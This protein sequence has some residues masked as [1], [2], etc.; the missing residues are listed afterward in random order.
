VPERSLTAERG[1]ESIPPGL[2]GSSISSYLHQEEA[3]RMSP[4]VFGPAYCQQLWPVD[5]KP[6]ERRAAAQRFAESV[7]S[8]DGICEVWL[9]AT[10]PDLDVAVVI[11]DLDLSI[12]LGIRGMFVDIVCEQLN[13][14]EGELSVYAL[15]DGVPGWVREG[16]RLIN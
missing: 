12:E 8:V 13:V 5:T 3:M 7:Q 4:Y 9:T 14:R 10:S 11:R 15:S 2:F 16:T 6:L 1:T